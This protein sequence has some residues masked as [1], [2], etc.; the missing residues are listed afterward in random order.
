MTRCDRTPCAGTLIH[1]WADAAH[2]DKTCHLCGRSE[3]ERRE[4][5][6]NG[7]LAHKA[8]MGKQLSLI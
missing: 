8:D 2:T 1:R 6:D 4:E 7:L 3:G 5:R